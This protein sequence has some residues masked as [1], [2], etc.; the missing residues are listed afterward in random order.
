MLSNHQFPVKEL[1]LDSLVLVVAVLEA[2]LTVAQQA[3]AAVAQPMA[4]AEH[5][6]AA[7]E[8]LVAA[9]E[10]QVT[11]VEQQVAAAAAAPTAGATARSAETDRVVMKGVVNWTVALL[12]YLGVVP[13]DVVL[14]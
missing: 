13:V 5:Q 14:Q 11:A 1:P 4:A 2:P 10:L 7:D 9:V 3:K 6:A 12:L 8:Q